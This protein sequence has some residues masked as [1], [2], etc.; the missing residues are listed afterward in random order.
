MR[1]LLRGPLWD[2]L[3]HPVG[4]RDE[5]V[6]QGTGL[7]P[8]ATARILLLLR[9]GLMPCFCVLQFFVSR[10]LCSDPTA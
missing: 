10:V 8:P 6:T 9:H 2:P 3:P 5:V 1:W 4:I 7:G